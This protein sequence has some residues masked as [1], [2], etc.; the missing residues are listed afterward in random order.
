VTGAAAALLATNCAGSG[1]S[2]P[3]TIDL[4]RDACSHCRMAIV[5]T[6]TAAEIVAPGDEPQLFDDLGCLRD[7]AATASLPPDAVVFVADHRTGAWADAR[8]A[9][10]TKTSLQTPMGSSLVAH[11]D[12]ASRDLDPA[13]RGG[14]GV[15]IGS[16]LR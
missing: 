2:G 6:A 11:A 4:G 3:V 7:F 8:H 1:A 15:S 10:F 14:S 5:S 12:T 16:I 13:A 9:V